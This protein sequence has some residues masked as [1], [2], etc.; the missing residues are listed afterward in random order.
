MFVRLQAAQHDGSQHSQTQH[1]YTQYDVIQHKVP[2]CWVSLCWVSLCWV[3]L[4]RVSLCWMLL[5][6]VSSHWLAKC[7]L[8]TS[9]D[10]I[11]VWCP[12]IDS[13]K[14]FHYINKSLFMQVFN[15]T[16]CFKMV[17]NYLNT[18]IYSYL[19]TSGGKSY[20][21]YSNISHFLT[22]VL[23]RHLWQLKT[24]VFLHW[25]LICAFPFRS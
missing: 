14:S 13:F 23:I 9:H 11:S 21:L 12:C 19:E 1:I 6:S 20:N 2:L 25:C 15:G 5:C 8:W 22:P 3:S 16:A 10:S 18:N 17:N 4:C 24:I 7:H